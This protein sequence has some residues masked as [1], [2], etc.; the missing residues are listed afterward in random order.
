[1]VVLSEEQVK[2]VASK[3][4]VS[5]DVVVQ[6]AE[7][8]PD[9]LVAEVSAKGIVRNIIRAWAC[10]RCVFSILP[11]RKTFWCIICMLLGGR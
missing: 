11:F 1:V 5:E 3:A 8:I 4:G 10:I 7:M 6:V 2:S 9:K